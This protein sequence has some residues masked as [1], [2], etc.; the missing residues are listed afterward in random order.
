[1]IVYKGTAHY[2]ATKTFD[3]FFSRAL[4]YELYPTT[5]VLTVRPFYV[6]TPMTKNI[7]S[8]T[9]CSASDTAVEVVNALGN[10]GICYGPLLHRFNGALVD[11][12][13]QALTTWTSSRSIGDFKKEYN[14]AD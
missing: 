7:T 1:M 4:S 13:N 11:L 2:S 10:A 5:D 12:A 8:L 6:S 14:K 9:F 3:D